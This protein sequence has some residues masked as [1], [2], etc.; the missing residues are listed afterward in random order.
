MELWTIG[1]LGISFPLFLFSIIVV[2][3]IIEVKRLKR[4]GDEKHQ[5]YVL[6]VKS[7]E[8]EKERVLD[9]LEDPKLVELHELHAPPPDDVEDPFRGSP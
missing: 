9:L 2:G 1:I 3:D 5:A 7:E 4:I 8:A 6:R